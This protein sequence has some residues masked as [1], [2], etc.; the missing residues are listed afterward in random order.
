MK[1]DIYHI[2]YL[3]WDKCYE[4]KYCS[5]EH[6]ELLTTFV[7]EVIVVIYINS[8][9][10]TMGASGGCRAT[11]HAKKTFQSSYK[12]NFKKIRSKTPYKKLDEVQKL[13]LEDLILLVAKGFFPLG[14][15]KKIWM[16][17]LALKLNPKLVFPFQRTLSK[18]IILRSMVTRCANLHVQ[19]QFDVTPTI[20]ITFDL[21]MNRG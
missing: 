12:C 3:F 21:W 19:T 2:Q 8:K 5:Y 13:F 15:C 7:E 18:E 10:Q 20:T 14:T 17:R 1:K 16:Q 4:K 9:S 11:H 6:L